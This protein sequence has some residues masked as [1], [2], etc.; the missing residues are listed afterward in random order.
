VWSDY[1]SDDQAMKHYFTFQEELDGLS[2]DQVSSGMFGAQKAKFQAIL[3]RL[4]L[5]KL[6]ETTTVTGNNYSPK[7]LSKF[8]GNMDCQPVC[9][10]HGAAGYAA[11]KYISK[12]DEPDKTMVRSKILRALCARP[13]VERSSE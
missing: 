4:E 6:A 5:E 7:I 3:H 11:G 1:L 2:E 12:Q 8:R 10:P 13:Q 9:N